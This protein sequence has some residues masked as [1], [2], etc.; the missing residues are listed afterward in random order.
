MLLDMIAF[1]AHPDDV[2][3]F[4]GG[5]ICRLVDQGRSVGIVDLSQG[6]LGT[7]G[8]AKLRKKEANEAAKI[9]GVNVR[10]N[11]GIPDGLVVDNLDNRR[12]LINVLRRFRPTIVIANDHRCRHPDHGGAAELVVSACFFS[13]SSIFDCFSATS[14]SRF[15]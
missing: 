14:F 2:E 7:R 13:N 6:E 1:G 15:S 4:A 5:T 8:S 12:L 3:L 9:S 10:E 11:L